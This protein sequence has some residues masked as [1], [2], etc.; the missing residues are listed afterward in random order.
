TAVDTIL[1]VTGLTPPV[2]PALDARA[3]RALS[4]AALQG[5]RYGKLPQTRSLH[6]L[7]GAPA[8]ADCFVAPCQEACPLHQD[9]PAY[10]AAMADGDMNRALM[11][12]SERNPLPFIT[13]TICPHLCVKNCNRRHLECAIDIRGLKLQAAEA[14]YGELLTHLWPMSGTKGKVAII[15]GG[16]A[17]MSAGYFLAKADFE[18]H[19]FEKS[20]SLGGVV[21][22]V[23]P[24]FRIGD[25]AIDKDISLLMAVGVIIHL[26][27]EI[28]ELDSLRQQGFTQIIVAVGAGVSSPLRLREGRADN[29]V[30]MLRQYKADPAL[31]RLG[32]SVAIVGGG[33][34]AMDA[35]RAA[36]RMPGVRQVTIVYRRD[37]QSI[38]ADEE[39]LALAEREGVVFRSQLAPV[40]HQ[41]GKLIC[42]KMELKQCGGQGRP[43]PQPTGELVELVVDTVI[44]ATGERVD[45]A[46]YETLGL[47]LT[48]GGLPVITAVGGVTPMAGVYVV[49]DGATG[50]ATVVEAIAQGAQAAQAI[51][52]CRMDALQALNRAAVP[53]APRGRILQPSRESRQEAQRCLSCTSYCGICVECCPNRANVLIDTAIGP[54]IVH[55]DA[56]CNECG[57]CACFCPY[58]QAPYQ[59]KFTIYHNL[60]DFSAGTNPGLLYT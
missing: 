29:A 10:V 48:A 24:D 40:S 53:G 2:P 13:G 58:Q 18:V 5:K 46:F 9:I 3:V 31:L 42:E 26:Q 19:I 44:A 57:N 22:Q 52:G 21:R 59:H 47:P 15:G 50:P 45:S 7:P 14:G 23:I 20:A 51:S 34:S 30:A 4:I 11:I 17:G 8:V 56:L 49:G 36:V 12:I 43:L 60:A 38:P 25:A 27:T 33:N 41:N 54:Q 55:I 32:A 1:P 35:A 6:K 16:P 39:E 37:R 28:R